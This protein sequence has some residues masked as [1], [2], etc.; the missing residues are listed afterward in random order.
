VPF[1]VAPDPDTDINPVLTTDA[2]LMGDPVIGP[3]T[4]K[5]APGSTIVTAPVKLLRLAE[6]P[7][8]NWKK[9]SPPLV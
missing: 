9:Y 6:P 4:V 1:R 5:D 7:D 2:V 3:S 8:A